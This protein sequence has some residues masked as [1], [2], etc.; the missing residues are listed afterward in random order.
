MVLTLLHR[1][2]TGGLLRIFCKERYCSYMAKK[3]SD[4]R[5]SLKETVETLVQIAQEHLARLPEEDQER[6][7]ARLEQRKFTARRGTSSKPAKTA[8]TI[9]T[10][11]S[12]RARR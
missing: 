1:T 9:Q 5:P 10:R 4:K 12:G 8:R 11:A 7:L 3:K 6:I 2:I